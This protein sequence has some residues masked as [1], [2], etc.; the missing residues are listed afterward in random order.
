MLTRRL[1]KY[2]WFFFILAILYEFSKGVVSLSG[3]FSPLLFLHLT[4]LIVGL[5]FSGIGI[6][7]ALGIFAKDKRL[8]KSLKFLIS[9]IIIFGIFTGFLIGGLS[10]GFW[11]LVFIILSFVVLDSWIYYTI[12]NTGL[13]FVLSLIVVWIIEKTTFGFAM[14]G[15]I[16]K[17]KK[18]EKD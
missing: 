8:W 6:I 2:L 18:K 7:C 10:S 9:L 14:L 3:L 17:R 13:F 5:C 12:F 16:L 4:Y 15:F 1:K 11:G